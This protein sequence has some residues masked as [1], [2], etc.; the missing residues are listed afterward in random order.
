MN[1]FFVVTRERNAELESNKMTWSCPPGQPYHASSNSF[2]PYLTCQK[3]IL[4]VVPIRLGPR[5]WR[6]HL[7]NSGPCT[8]PTPGLQH[9]QSIDPHLA[10]TSTGRGWWK[11][12]L[13]GKDSLLVL[14]WS[15]VVEMVRIRR[16]RQGNLRT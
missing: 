2:L 4:Y 8:L 3:Q 15:E 12:F 13:S 11:D 14:F 1:I 10:R 5:I 16:E 7:L 9:S 6:N